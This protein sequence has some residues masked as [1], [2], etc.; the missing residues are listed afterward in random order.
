MEKKD[1]DQKSGPYNHMYEWTTTNQ[2]DKDTCCATQ[3]GQFQPLSQQ[4]AEMNV[5]Q[6]RTC[7]IEWRSSFST[8]MYGNLKS[9]I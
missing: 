5:L 8:T 4:L 9:L 2:D 3:K 1:R 7:A 6:E